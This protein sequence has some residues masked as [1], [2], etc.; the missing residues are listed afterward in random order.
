MMIDDDATFLYNES[1][2]MQHRLLFLIG[3]VMVMVMADGDGFW[4]LASGFWP[5]ASGDGLCWLLASG[6]W[7]LASDFWSPEV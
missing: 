3:M 4:L 5:L 6:F 1:N 7:L 2:T